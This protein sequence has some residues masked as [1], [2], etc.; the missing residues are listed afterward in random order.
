MLTS[1]NKQNRKILRREVVLVVEVAT[2]PMVDV[3]VLVFM[4]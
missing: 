3:V 1:F 2:I 4:K